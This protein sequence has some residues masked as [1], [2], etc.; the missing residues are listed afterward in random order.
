MAA[1]KIGR[2]KSKQGIGWR[3]CVTTVKKKSRPEQMADDIPAWADHH[4][5]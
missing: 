1:C 4:K 2:A 3:C 5:M